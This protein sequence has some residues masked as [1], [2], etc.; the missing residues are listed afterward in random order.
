MLAWKGLGR[1]TT[2]RLSPFVLMKRIMRTRSSSTARR[3]PPE[4]E[5]IFEISQIH[6][7]PTPTVTRLTS[8]SPA[9]RCHP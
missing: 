4:A 5:R 8:Q 1:V 9:R 6:T 7:F 3:Q 2:C